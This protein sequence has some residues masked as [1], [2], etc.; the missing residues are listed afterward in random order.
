MKNFIILIIGIFYI[1][2][3]LISSTVN[4]YPYVVSNKIMELSKV[5]EQEETIGKQLGTTCW[6]RGPEELIYPEKTFMLDYNYYI[7]VEFKSNCDLGDTVGLYK[8]SHYS[9]DDGFF[10]CSIREYTYR[11]KVEKWQF[12]LSL[13]EMI[14]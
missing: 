6:D 4:R 1:L 3:L 8:K 11:A 13:W 12:K 9:C 2:L 5:K 10:G 7:V 14:M